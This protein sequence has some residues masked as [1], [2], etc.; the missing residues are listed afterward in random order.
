MQNVMFLQWITFFS[1]V[2]KRHAERIT[3]PN[4]HRRKIHHFKYFQLHLPWNAANCR[5][6]YNCQV[7]FTL[8]SAASFNLRQA[9]SNRQPRAKTELRSISR[10]VDFSF[11][12][13]WVGMTSECKTDGGDGNAIVCRRQLYSDT[14][15]VLY[16]SVLLLSEQ[17][18]TSGS[19]RRLRTH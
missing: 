4:S 7:V 2:I 13:R 9:T 14:T 15:D 12:H 17:C 16:L 8:Q 5:F 18:P 3:Q 19:H 6:W 1:A 11:A 10:S